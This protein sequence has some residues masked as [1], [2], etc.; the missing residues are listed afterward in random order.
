MSAESNGRAYARPAAPGLSCAHEFVRFA[1][2]GASP[3]HA[4]SVRHQFSVRAC[5]NCCDALHR[6]R[7]GRFPS[8]HLE[9]TRCVVIRDA[10]PAGMATG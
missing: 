7:L 4:M 8:I 3:K 6:Q 5:G 1:S 2:V 9:V 10:L